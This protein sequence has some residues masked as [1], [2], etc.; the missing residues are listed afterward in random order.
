MQKRQPQTLPFVLSLEKDGLSYRDVAPFSFMLRLEL[1][2][3]TRAMLDRV[4]SIFPGNLIK[5]LVN[6]RHLPDLGHVVEQCVLNSGL[7]D[8]A[9]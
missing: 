5:A 1:G 6:L 8:K 7:S 4:L 2:W 3:Q 9:A